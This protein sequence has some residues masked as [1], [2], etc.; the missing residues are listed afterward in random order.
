MKLLKVKVV[1]LVLLTTSLVSN[2]FAAAEVAFDLHAQHF[3]KAIEGVL[4][5]GKVRTAQ[6]LCYNQ[7]KVCRW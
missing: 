1:A 4:R 2:A 5:R 3:S 6:G 7:F